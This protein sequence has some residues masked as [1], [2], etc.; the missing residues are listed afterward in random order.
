MFPFPTEIQIRTHE[1]DDVAEFGVAAHFA[2][3]EAHQ[4]IFVPEAQSLWIKKLQDLVTTYQSSDEK[5][6]FKKELNIEVLDKRIF[7]YTPK[8]DVIE[9]PQ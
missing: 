9:L 6:K 2:Y 8:G 1:M 7:V 5:E 3:S 4:P